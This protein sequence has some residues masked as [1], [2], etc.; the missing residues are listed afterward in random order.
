MSPEIQSL[1]LGRDLQFEE[2]IDLS[3]HSGS[4][5]D[6]SSGST[7]LDGSACDMYLDTVG[8]AKTSNGEPQAGVC[9]NSQ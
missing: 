6:M 8:S 3:T 5:L 9:Y 2:Q 4:S 7:V 1:R